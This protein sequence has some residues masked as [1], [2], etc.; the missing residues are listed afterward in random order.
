MLWLRF[1][2]VVIGK[3]AECCS[4]WSSLWPQ[5]PVT[6]TALTLYLGIRTCT[7]LSDK[8]TRSRLFHHGQCT[9]QAQLLQKDCAM[10]C[11]LD[12]VNCCKSAH[13]KRFAIGKWPLQPLKVIRNDAIR[14]TYIISTFLLNCLLKNCNFSYH[15]CIW[16]PCWDNLI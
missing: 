8:V 6:F 7:K 4:P 9:E 1:C 16:Y 11:Q 5:R 12:L 3:F 15:T 14:Q 10:L 13:F 2:E